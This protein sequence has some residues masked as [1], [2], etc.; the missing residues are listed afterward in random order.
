MMT[1]TTTTIIDG[2][3]LA[4]LDKWVLSGTTENQFVSEIISNN[5][6]NNNNNNNI[7]KW[8]VVIGY[9]YFTFAIIC[10]CSA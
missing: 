2:H 9:V 5:N 6:N 3:F 4:S 1:T 7:N 8:K 10:P